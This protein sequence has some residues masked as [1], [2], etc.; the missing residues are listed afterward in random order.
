MAS[1]W[2]I[3][4]ATALD[5]LNATW[6]MVWWAAQSKEDDYDTEEAALHLA[7]I[8]NSLNTFRR[9]REILQPGLE[10]STSDSRHSP[11]FD[12]LALASAGEGSRPDF[13]LCAT[14]HEKAFQLLRIA[15][16][17]VEDRLNDELDRRGAPDS[18]L[19]GISDLRRQSA[20]QL[21]DTLR[22]L[23]KNYS[24]ESI[25]TARRLH[26][27]RAWIDREWATISNVN[28][29]TNTKR[30]E[31]E[32]KAGRPKGADISKD[33]TDCLRYYRDDGKKPSDIDEMMLKKSGSRRK[34]GDSW[35]W[36]TASKVIEAAKARGEI[37]RKSRKEI[38]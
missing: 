37:P 7:A 1:D 8:E 12:A 21:S 10:C 23:G 36:G 18:H 13:K 30:K 17:R 35:E 11:V 6:D 5:C 26:E 3:V 14:A 38:S 9:A 4:R 22:C 20:S 24:P 34:N 15:I 16:L 27:L 28:L 19:L 31:S 2:N 32:K 33:E 29:K 25:L